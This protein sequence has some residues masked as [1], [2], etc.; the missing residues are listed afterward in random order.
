MEMLDKAMARG[1]SVG[2]MPPMR[3]LLLLLLSVCL[4]AA[5]KGGA[6]TGPDT[7]GWTGQITLSSSGTEAGKLVLTVKDGQLTAPTMASLLGVPAIP[8]TLGSA[9]GLR[10]NTVK[11]TV[12]GAAQVGAKTLSLNGTLM[13][14]GKN[15]AF[16]GTIVL[17]EQ[18][19]SFTGWLAPAGAQVKTAEPT[20]GKAAK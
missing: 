7:N 15:H 6:G 13:N 19:I 2:R 14:Q 1:R 4:A 20:V 18:T 11:L 3:C 9:K 17:G 8:F 12:T 10:P 5:E 16:D